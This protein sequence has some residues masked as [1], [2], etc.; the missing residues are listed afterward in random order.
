MQTTNSMP[1]VTAGTEKPWYAHRWPWLLMLGPVL[2]ILA[3]IHTT[4]LAF[5][6]PDALVVDDYYKQGKAIN[7]DLRRDRL[8]QGLGMAIQL[9]Y[10]A[11]AGR[12]QGKVSSRVPQ[13][14]NILIKLVHSTQPD[15][16][17]ALHA[18]P[19]AQGGFSVALPMLDIAR[20]QVVVEGERR[21]WRLHG[22]W[23]WPQQKEMDIRT[24]TALAG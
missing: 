1:C 15:K 12:L 17:I 24:D 22:V 6:Q 3:G 11:E 21:D 2:V 4:W 20:W 23:P 8:A 13:Q 19:D 9:R 7:Q 16:D 10:D 18:T 14:G 5:S